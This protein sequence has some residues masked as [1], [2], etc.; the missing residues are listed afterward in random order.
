MMNGGPVAWSSKRQKSVSLSSTEAEYIALCI[1]SCE[2][3]HLR[4]VLTD[5]QAPQN[6]PT[7]MFEDNSGCV[8]LT[9]DD[10][11]HRKTKHIEIRYHK[12]REL[13]A[14][15]EVTITQ[16]PAQEQLADFCTKIHGPTSFQRL[17]RMFMGR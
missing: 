6:G 17:R 11:M 9:R 10:V 1:A 16:V 14:E 12:V 2:A 15:Q 13:G 5:L 3:V 4:R 7:E 8:Q